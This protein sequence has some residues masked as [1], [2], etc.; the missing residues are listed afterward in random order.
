[1]SPNTINL[2]GWVTSMAPVSSLGPDIADLW[3]LNGPLLPQN[4]LE[5]LGGF[6]PH[7]FQWVL[8]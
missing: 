2:Y 8:R 5:K 7:L 4:P 3:G 6:A 1:M